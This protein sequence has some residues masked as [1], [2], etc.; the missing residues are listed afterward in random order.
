MHINLFVS[1]LAHIAFDLSANEK[2]R[3]FPCDQGYSFPMQRKK[4]RSS[5]N[6]DEVVPIEISYDI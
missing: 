6:E 4:T 3:F 5:G 1:K 2:I